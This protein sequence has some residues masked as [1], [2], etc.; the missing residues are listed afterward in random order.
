VGRPNVGKST[1]LN[2]LVGR[3][4]SMVTAKPQTTRSRIRGIWDTDAGQMVLVDTPGIHRPRHLLGR[5]MV[6]AA[7]EAARDVDLI[8]HVVDLTRAPGEE[9][10]WAADLIH[11]THIPGWL[12]GNKADRVED[13]AARLA[14]YQGFAPY[15]RAWTV[16]ALTGAGVPEL[17]AA[18]MAALP[19]GPRFFPR[20]MVTDQAED[21]YIA[22]VVRAQILEATRD[23]VPHAVAVVVEERLARRPDLT[24]IRATVY[25][26]RES[27]RAILL[28][29]GGRM[30]KAIGAQS[31]AQLEAYYGHQVYLDLW[32]K[33]EPRWRDREDWI[34]RLTGAGEGGP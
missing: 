25:V 2:A 5:R 12:I 18:G 14:P 10:R 6:H 29:A 32:V 4:V 34:R 17:A 24:Y 3:D 28:G 31:R 21:F 16:A 7:Q 15:Q 26:E 8:W 23:E 27:Q 13:A 20:D 19:A 30:L 9:D 11:R 22:E 33:V 1:L